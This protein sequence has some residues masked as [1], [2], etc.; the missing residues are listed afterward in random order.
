MIHYQ[1][2]KRLKKTIKNYVS[3]RLKKYKLN[4]TKLIDNNTVY[5]MPDI[6]FK[7]EDNIELEIIIDT[8]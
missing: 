4:Y 5:I 3:M 8:V 7:K 6:S 1:K 2:V